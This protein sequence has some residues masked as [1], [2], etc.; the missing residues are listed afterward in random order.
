MKSKYSHIAWNK[1][2]KL[3]LEHR[4]NLSISHKG[5]YGGEKHWNWKRIKRNC[6]Q[7]NKE[8]FVKYYL[9]KQGF[10]KYCC[11]KC[12]D[13]ARIGMFTGENHPCW[14]NGNYKK[15][16]ERNDSAYQDWVKKVKRRDNYKCQIN[17]QDC[18]GYC[19]VHHI[20]LIRDYPELI[21]EINNG[22][23]L[24]QAH[25]PRKRAEEKRL[26]PQFK[27]LVSVSN[28]LI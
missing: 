10:G 3:S 19:I 18:L 6:L 5:K 7:C 22:I 17:N 15:R 12:A 28:G 20:L 11:K 21:Y 25:H 24:C 16:Q 23:T 14:V 4:K 13:I 2:K 1:G 26:I 8:F 9:A 27:E